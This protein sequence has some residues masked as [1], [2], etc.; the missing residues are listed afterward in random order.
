MLLAMGAL[1]FLRL[2]WIADDLPFLL[3]RTQEALGFVI[4]APAI[5]IA[6]LWHPRLAMILAGAILA[7]TA[8]LMLV[9]AL[10]VF[11]PELTQLCTG[12]PWFDI[13]AD[14]VRPSDVACY[15]GGFPEPE[16]SRTVMLFG[17]ASSALALLCMMLKW[18]REV[19]STAI[20]A[21]TALA[22]VGLLYLVRYV[23][24]G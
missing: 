13:P 20:A 10:G 2:L 12:F 14:Q 17:A 4:A 5:L 7:P 19:V 16:P 24:I 15:G 22:V 11:T 6:A 8:V 18:P 23:A 1:A 21:A 9:L 3:P